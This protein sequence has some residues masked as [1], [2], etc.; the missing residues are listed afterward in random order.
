MSSS[1]LLGKSSDFFEMRRVF[2]FAVRNIRFAEYTRK[3][4]C[5]RIV[6]KVLCL[7][8]RNFIFDGFFFKDRQHPFPLCSG[9]F[10]D[11]LFLLGVNFVSCEDT[12]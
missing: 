4:Q 1:D 3:L 5:G 12:V 10:F 11:F 7:K 8:N 9:I 6:C 2:L